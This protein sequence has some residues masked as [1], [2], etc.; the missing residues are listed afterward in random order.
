MSYG[1][2]VYR[3]AEADLTTIQRFLDRYKKRRYISHSI[4]IH[5]LL[6]KKKI[7]KIRTKVMGLEDHTLYD[8]LP[9]VI[10]N[11]SLYHLRRK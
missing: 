11:T 3:A 6:E 2:A 1:L 5:D 9:E 7:K 10:K 8:M 4:D